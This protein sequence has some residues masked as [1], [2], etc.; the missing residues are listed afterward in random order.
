MAGMS[1]TASQAPASAA[2]NA[3]D[4]TFSQLIIFLSGFWGEVILIVS[5]ALMAFGMW[6]GKKARP[7][8]LALIAASLLFIG[9]YVYFSIGL[10][11]AGSVILIL[12]YTSVYNPRFAVLTKLG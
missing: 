3:W 5:F 8:I 7:M 9:M 4:A 10:E 1:G 2:S 12:A 11:L 6:Y